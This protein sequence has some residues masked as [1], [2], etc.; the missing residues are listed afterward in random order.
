MA[1]KVSQSRAPSKYL[2]TRAARSAPESLSVE[3]KAAEVEAASA[4]GWEGWGGSA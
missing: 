2:V 3:A 1:R 4:G